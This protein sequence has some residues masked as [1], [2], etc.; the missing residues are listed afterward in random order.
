MKT[1]I[2][3]FFMVFCFAVMI[4]GC[5]SDTPSNTPESDKN[6]ELQ[7]ANNTP[8]NDANQELQPENNTPEPPAV[9]NDE[10]ENNEKPESSATLL[11]QG[12]GSLRI[13]TSEG[14]VI[15]IDPYMGEGYD[16]PADLILVTHPHPDHTAIH[17]I[18][19]QNTDCEIITYK[20]ALIDGEHKTFEFDYVTVEAVEAG[21]NP[22]HDI[23]VCVG[24]ILTLSDGKSI[25]ITGDT[26]KTEQMSAFPERNLDYA[27][28]CGDGIYNMDIDEAAEC[29]LFVGAKNNIPYHLSPGENFNRERAELFEAPNR[30]I[31]ADGE[32]IIL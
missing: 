26:S 5:A 18:E 6:Q 9:T 32:E 23:N 31:I 28:F 11:Y 20:E 3:L 22:N 14:K 30:M 19:T 17:L 27:F 21:N 4:T 15:Y 7:P 12:H 1:K 8:E 25:Y 2:S 16:V 24:Y 29:A 13:T 10:Q